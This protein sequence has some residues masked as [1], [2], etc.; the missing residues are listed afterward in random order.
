MSVLLELV[1][2]YS[3]IFVFAMNYSV[4]PKVEPYPRFMARR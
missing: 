3:E 2:E 1:V 4:N